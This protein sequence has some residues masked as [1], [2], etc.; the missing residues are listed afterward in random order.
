[1]HHLPTIPLFPGGQ[2]VTTPGALALLERTNK[3]PTEFLSR[4]LRADRVISAQ[5]TKPKTN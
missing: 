2:I 4:H 5:R 3:A 1:M